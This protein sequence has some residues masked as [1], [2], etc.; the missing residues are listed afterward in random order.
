MSKFACISVTHGV[1]SV[2]R[3]NDNQRFQHILTAYCIELTLVEEI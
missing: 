2:D 1:Q 3:Y